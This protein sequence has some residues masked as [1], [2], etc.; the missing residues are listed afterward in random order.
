MPRK[1]EMTVWAAVITGLDICQ[2]SETPLASLGEF[3]KKLGLKGWHLADVQTV[4]RCVLEL[5]RCQRQ[6]EAASE[7]EEQPVRRPT[8]L[9]SQKLTQAA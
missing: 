4:E 9:A 1:P 8:S 3:L 5:L 7:R 6:Q 2:Q